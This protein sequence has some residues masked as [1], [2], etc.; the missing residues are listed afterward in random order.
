MIEDD[1][2]G[3]VLSNSVRERRGIANEKSG[4]LSTGR[5]HLSVSHRCFQAIEDRVEVFM[6]EPW[7]LGTKQT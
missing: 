6:H 4:L 7:V 2:D 3:K 5:K 1:Q